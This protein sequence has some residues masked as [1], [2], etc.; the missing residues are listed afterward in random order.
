[1]SIKVL[2]VA[3]NALDY[4][5]DDEIWRRFG[6]RNAP[7]HHSPL[8]ALFQHGAVAR[9]LLLRQELW[10]AANASVFL[11]LRFHPEFDH[12]VPFLGRLFEIAVD[13]VEGPNGNGFWRC[14]GFNDR[15]EALECLSNACEDYLR[16]APTKEQVYKNENGTRV[17]WERCKRR[18]SHEPP[19]VWM[20]GAISL[21]VMYDPNFWIVS[22]VRDLGMLNDA[23]FMNPSD[24]DMTV[25]DDR[26]TSVARELFDGRR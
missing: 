13:G 6:Y 5:V 10:C 11:F 3:R 26:Y 22:C 7:K 24:C 9:D 21:F 16:A 19:E 23:G 2:L 17:F 4:I 14:L 8:K 12:R 15:G 1:M 20:A 18:S 25:N